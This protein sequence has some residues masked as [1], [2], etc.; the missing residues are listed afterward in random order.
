[1]ISC[2]EMVQKIRAA[3]D[4]RTDRDLQIIARTDAIAVEGIDRA[5][6]RAHAYIQAGADVTFVEAP[7]SISDMTRIGREIAAPQVANIVFGGKTPDLGRMQLA[8]MGYSIVLYANA[9][10]QASMKAS[11]E[12][13]AVLKEK[14]SLVLIA[15][16]IGEFAER[17]R[18]VAKETWDEREARYRE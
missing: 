9:A 1:M 7:T 10:L 4:A 6:E 17:Q 5:I 18:V 15:D 8:K 13:L 2:S 16:R 14:H 12:V 3:T 11:Q